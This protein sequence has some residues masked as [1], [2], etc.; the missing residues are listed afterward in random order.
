MLLQFPNKQTSTDKLRAKNDLNY[1]YFHLQY[2]INESMY[3][4]SWA[5][6]SSVDDRIYKFKRN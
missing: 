1:Y 4:F 5:L 2:T 6:G 3:L